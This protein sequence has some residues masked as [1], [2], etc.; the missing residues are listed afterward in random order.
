MEHNLLEHKN[1]A[2]IKLKRKMVDNTDKD[3]KRNI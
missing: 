3:H 2:T 1:A